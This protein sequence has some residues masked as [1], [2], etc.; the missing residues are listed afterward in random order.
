MRVICEKFSYSWIRRLLFITLLFS[1]FQTRRTASNRVKV[2][3]INLVG[4]PK[5]ELERKIKMKF[6]A[7]IA[8]ID[9]FKW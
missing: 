2:I 6:L 4:R 1:N 7:K 9:Y 5:E 8:S 3:R